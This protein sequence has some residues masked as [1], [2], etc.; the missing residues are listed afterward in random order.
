MIAVT[1]LALLAL[2]ACMLPASP[3][4]PAPPRDVD[5]PS[6]VARLSYS[7]GPISFEPAGSNEWATAELN[8]PFTSGDQIWS[9]SGARAEFDLGS[10]ALRADHE[11]SFAI[12]DLTDD[13]AQFRLTSGVINIRVRRLDESE[14]IEIDTPNAAISLLRP[15][16]YRFEVRPADDLTSVV[17]RGGEAQVNGTTQSFALHA[18]QSASIYGGESTGYEIASAPGYDPF[19]EFCATRERRFESLEARRYVSP[20]VIGY[21]D[22]DEFGA[23]NVDVTWGPVWVPRAVPFGWA[24]YRFGHWVWIE[25]WGWTWIDDT[26]WG[27]APFHYGR[28]AYIGVNWCWVPGP[29]HVRPVYA[30][31]LVVFVGGGRPGFDFFFWAGGGAGVA[32]FPLGPR[33]VYMPPF[34]ASPRFITNINISNTVIANPDRIHGMDMTRQPYMNRAVQGAVTAVPRDAFTGAKPI[35]RA[36]I[37]VP[38]RDAIA[39]RIAGTAAPVAPSRESLHAPGTVSRPPAPAQ[40]RPAVVRRTPPPAPVPFEQKRGALDARPGKPPDQGTLDQLRRTQPRTQPLTQPDVRPAQGGMVPRPQAAPA[41]QQSQPRAAQS[42]VRRQQQTDANRTRSIQ[43]ERSRE[44]KQQQA[45]KPAR[46]PPGRGE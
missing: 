35:S 36:A 23:W 1:V 17:I 32:W 14:T 43:T 5:P 11:T 15:G 30:P 28:W 42:D 46:R 8:R 40:Q 39:G 34:H 27:F 24:P 12:L 22:L 13:A 38:A 21:E 37:D 25:P 26:P 10:A 19:D 2:P 45:P 18:G 6:R 16:E 20:E 7:Q 29:I 33:E 3:E 31:A 9:G 4:Q 41:P 44:Q